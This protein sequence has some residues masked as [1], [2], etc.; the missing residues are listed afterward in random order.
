MRPL[1][2]V[3]VDEDANAV[4]VSLITVPTEVLTETSRGDGSVMDKYQFN[5]WEFSV[6]V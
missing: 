6:D 2:S 5:I 4:P 3:H 1:C